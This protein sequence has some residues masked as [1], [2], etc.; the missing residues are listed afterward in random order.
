MKSLTPPP[1]SSQ[2]KNAP[3]SNIF[4]SFWS[5]ISATFLE[6]MFSQVLSHSIIYTQDQYK[7]TLIMLILVRQPDLYKNLIFYC[8]EFNIFCSPTGNDTSGQS[9]VEQRIQSASLLS[10]SG[11]ET[12]LDI[13]GLTM[14]SFRGALVSKLFLTNAFL[15]YVRIV[16]HFFSPPSRM[17]YSDCFL[18]YFKWV[19][20][21]H[22]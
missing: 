20:L 8:F 22:G 4:Y 7:H 11:L 18:L 12:S 5:W 1:P 21:C 6:E 3:A 2:I 17:F 13:N 10:S 14:L 16:R 19:V 9:H 15:Q